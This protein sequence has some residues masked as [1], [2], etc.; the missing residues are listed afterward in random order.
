MNKLFASIAVLTAGL[1]LI[2][3]VYADRDEG[4]DRGDGPTS[5]AVY[6]DAPYGCKARTAA[7][8]PDECPA[9]SSY[10][11]DSPNGPN[12]GD[13]RQLEATPAF[14]AAVNRDP[15]VR[16]VLHV[17]DIHSGSGYCTQAYNQRV[18]DL[19]SDYKDPLV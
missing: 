1:T 2:A 5:L 12:P 18:L 9:G 8:A 11:P 19:W 7:A 13:A 6:G 17:G 10:A 16:L 4:D 3:P 14:I 15:K